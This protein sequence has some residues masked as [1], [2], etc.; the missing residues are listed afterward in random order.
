MV[1]R[2]L[3]CDS[4]L[5]IPLLAQGRPFGVLALLSKRERPVREWNHRLAKG[6][7]QEAALAISNARLYESAQQKHRGLQVRLRHLES[8]AET[9][10]HDLKGPGSRM[11]ELAK[12]LSQKFSGLVDEHT[13]RLLKLIQENGS[14]IVQ[15][16]EAILEVARVGVGQGAV[17]AVDPRLV[18][19]EVLKARVGEIE[20]SHATVHVEPGFPP[21]VCHAAYL[22]Q[23][24][25]NLI[26]N[27]LKYARPGKP[28]VLTISSRIEQN[29]A[30][31][32]V[33]DEGIGIPVNQRTRVFQPFVR[34]MRS[35]AMGSGIGLTIVQRI[36]DLYG[37]SVGIEGSGDEGCTV[38]FSLPR[39]REDGLVAA[40][41]A[42]ITDLPEVMNVSKTDVI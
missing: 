17:M 32:S 6:L 18:L 34:L 33:R 39:L 2:N 25:D 42:R 7:A 5:A 24:F 13:G 22:R 31:F 19:D 20:Q 16:V 15:R 28:P 29:M 1:R 37:G 36:V 35:D 3:I 4:M 30:C 8:L 12:L 9:L 40:H 14:D 41:P 27:A 10:A 26:S 23:V 38:T 11:E 21:V